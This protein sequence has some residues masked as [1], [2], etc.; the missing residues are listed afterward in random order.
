MNGWIKC[1][2][3]HNGVLLSHLPYRRKLHHPQ[4]SGW[5]EEYYIKQNKQNSERLM[6]YLLICG[7]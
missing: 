6:F 7:H 3:L 5:S 4:E 1:D 2:F